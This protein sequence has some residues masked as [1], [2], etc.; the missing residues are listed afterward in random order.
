MT[1]RDLTLG[2]NRHPACP[3]AETL[4]AVIGTGRHQ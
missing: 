2:H 1:F 4:A 3:H